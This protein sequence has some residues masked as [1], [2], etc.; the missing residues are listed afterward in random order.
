[1]HN[2]ELIDIRE[3]ATKY[4]RHWKWFL[5]SFFVVGVLSVAYLKI[6]SPTFEVKANLLVKE[7]DSKGGMGSSMLKSFSFGF[8]GS[9]D[10]D[11]ELHVI[12]SHSILKQTALKLGL[13][14][15]YVETNYGIKSSI[16]YGDEAIR[17]EAVDFKLD[18]LS[19]SL[20][21]K[22]KLKSNGG[23]KVVVTKG[24]KTLGEFTVEKL[25]ADIKTEYGTLHLSETRYRRAGENQ[26]YR[27]VIAG[28]DLLAED[29]DRDVYFDLA[30]KKAN[31][32]RISTQTKNTKLGRDII[33]TIMALYNDD[34]IREKNIE[35]ENTSLFI[36]ERLR[37]ITK[38][39][40]DVEA[41]IES[42]KKNNRLFDVEAEAKL[43][44][45][46]NS[47]LRSKILDVETQY[48]IVDL[49]YNFVRLPENRYSLVP[50]SLGITD[51]G[52]VDAIQAY[53]TILLE[54][55][56]LI[57][58]TQP[59]NPMVISINE[60]I[61]AMRNNVLLSIEAVRQGLMVSRVDLSKQE[62]LFNSRYTQAPTIEKEFV[63]IKRKQVLKEQLYLFL[64]EKREENSLTLAVTAPKGKI[65]DS[66][67]VISEPVA[68]R[69]K[70]ILLVAMAIG[71]LIPIIVIYILD[72]LRVH[73]ESKSELEK[74]TTIPVLGEICLNKSREN[75]VVK[76]G[77]TSSI[78]ELFRLI[79][80]NI[81][82]VLNRK[83]EKVILVTSTVSG[84]GK[85]FVAINFALS[86]SLM[87]NKK[88]VLVGLDIRKPRLV[89]Y[90]EMNNNPIGI[91]NYLSDEDLNPQDIAV[92]SS[93]CGNLDII[94]SGPIPPNP[95][96]L[97][98]GERLDRMF[99]YLRH[100]YDYIV[101]DSAPVGMVSDTF[102]LA[103]VTD[104][105]LYVCRANY[106]KRENI[107]YAESIVAQNRLKKVSL[108]I[109]G[110]QTQ[111]GYGYG[112]GEKR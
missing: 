77:S 58:N 112:Y 90:M 70:F 73:F 4:L 29:L 94:V 11:D 61:E 50:N 43:M 81:Q 79:R 104:A 55:I 69:K 108:I 13:T 33:N 3:L 67:F 23:A 21:L 97:L 62:D 76:E 36:D 39:L 10:V 30:S 65:I 51:K 75:V 48:N 74:M 80:T 45:E 106:S 15:R 95:A 14:T 9:M 40:T 26:D 8:P 32:I 60:Q 66:A 22:A 105:T 102:S 17:L 88:V 99:D 63:E 2:Q 37:I 85:S 91:T 18:T 47:D 6:V 52:A 42:Y 54:R 64:M 111:T 84:E 56:K 101:V 100:H 78:V 109:N 28:G 72:L 16:R 89:E 57:Q 86:L 25:P 59:N 7:D 83:D 110:T 35:S 71:G 92:H 31:V 107:K 82:F 96:E 53:N 41:E 98:L 34:A 12:S 27:V 1:M 19:V 49:L 38:E 103:R 44:L 20:I 5:L 93:I 24:R 68:P 46:Q 87:K